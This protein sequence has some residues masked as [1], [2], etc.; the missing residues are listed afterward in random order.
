VPLEALVVVATVHRA[1][2]HAAFPLATS[3][4]VAQFAHTF[5]PAAVVRFASRLWQ[6]WHLAKGSVSGLTGFGLGV[7]IL[8]MSLLPPLITLPG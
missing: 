8:L 4:G 6:R 5:S 2:A 3:V 1:L 7:F